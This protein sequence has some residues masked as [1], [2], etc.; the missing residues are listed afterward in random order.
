MIA[1]P[2]VRG[3]GSTG[4]S[5]LPKD[6]D[7]AFDAIPKPGQRAGVLS[8]REIFHLRSRLVLGTRF[9]TMT[10]RGAFDLRPVQGRTGDKPRQAAHHSTHTS[11]LSA[12]GSDLPDPARCRLTLTPPADALAIGACLRTRPAPTTMGLPPRAH[13]DRHAGAPQAGTRPG[14]PSG[15]GVRAA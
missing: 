12:R 10:G 2:S 8:F 11:L 1:I 9:V 7:V 5:S 15:K 3:T 14:S 4:W 13:R 6:R